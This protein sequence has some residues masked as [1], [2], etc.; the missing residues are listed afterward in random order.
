M[1]PNTPSSPQWTLNDMSVSQE[2]SAPPPTS[3]HRIEEPRE[4]LSRET[5]ER[6]ESEIPPEDA[7]PREARKGWWQR[8]F[9]M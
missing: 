1:S 6:T 2:R 4:S 8:R 5:P 9:K 7:T 3:E